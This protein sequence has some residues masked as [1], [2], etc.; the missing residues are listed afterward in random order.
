MVG[1][2]LLLFAHKIDEVV[3]REL[4]NRAFGCV[5][6]QTAKLAHHVH[7]IVKV[8]G[9]SDPGPIVAACVP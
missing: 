7:L 9:M 6:C 8:S 3:W 2:L 1:L 4:A 5:A